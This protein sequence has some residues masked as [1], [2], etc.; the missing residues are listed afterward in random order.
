MNL[1]TRW[2]D[3]TK[4]IIN[5]NT[6]DAEISV[7]WI[8]A[9]KLIQNSAGKTMIYGVAILSTCMISSLTPSSFLSQIVIWVC[10]ILRSHTCDCVELNS[11]FVVWL[12]ICACYFVLLCF[13]FKLIFFLG[14]EKTCLFQSWL[15]NFGPSHWESDW[16]RIWRIYDDSFGG[17]GNKANENW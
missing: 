17:R 14:R 2:L 6:V 13:I 16:S 15:Y 8:I 5:L 4:Y 7:V 9:I 11:C 10:S 3:I 12:S 1:F